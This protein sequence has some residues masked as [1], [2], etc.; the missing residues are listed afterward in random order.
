MNLAFNGGIV[1]SYTLKKNNSFVKN[2]SVTK[3]EGILFPNEDF[4]QYNIGFTAGLQLRINRVLAL[5]L[6]GETNRGMSL[7]NSVFSR[8]SSF[9]MFISYRLY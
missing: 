3:A 9:N 8:L 1:H 7:Y 5:E 6:R 4:K 2:T